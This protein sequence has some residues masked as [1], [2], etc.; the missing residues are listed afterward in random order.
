MNTSVSRTVAE[1]GDADP[2]DALDYAH[3]VG[4]IHRDIKPGNLMLDGGWQCVDATD[5]GLGAKSRPT[6]ASR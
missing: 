4:V 6:R 5:F 1:W 3:G 2:A